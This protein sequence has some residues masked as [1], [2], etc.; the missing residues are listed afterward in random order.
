MADADTVEVTNN[1]RNEEST[2]NR[3]GAKSSRNEL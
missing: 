1:G 3:T 2:G